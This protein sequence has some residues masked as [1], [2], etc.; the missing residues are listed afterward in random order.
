[1]T[2][3]PGRPRTLTVDQIVQATLADGL[4]TFSMPSVARRVGVARDARALAAAAESARGRAP[5]C[6]R[7]RLGLLRFGDITPSF[8]ALLIPRVVWRNRQEAFPV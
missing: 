8:C 3:K 7:P 2:G 6:D 4:T 1:M 5:L